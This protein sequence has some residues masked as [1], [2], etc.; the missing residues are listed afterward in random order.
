[1]TGYY[2][3][4]HE[5]SHN[6]GCNHNREVSS[7]T[8]PFSHAYLDPNGQFRTIMGYNCKNGCPRIQRF[9]N[10]EIDYSNKNIGS[11]VEDNSRQINNVAG[12]VADWYS[13][14]TETVV[15]VTESPTASPTN[16]PT[17]NLFVRNPNCMGVADEFGVKYLYASDDSQHGNNWFADF[18]TTGNYNVDDIDD[19]RLGFHT[20]GYMGLTGGE[21]LIRGSSI[22]TIS[23]DDSSEGFQNV[24]LTT[25]VK[26]ENFGRNGYESSIILTTHAEA[27][28]DD[29]VNGGCDGESYS[30][31]VNR[32]TGEVQFDKMYFKRGYREVRSAPISTKPESLAAG[33]PLQEYIGLKFVVY[34][35]GALDVKLELYIDQTGG[36][37]GGQWQLVHEFLDSQDAW[38]AERGWHYS[39]FARSQ[40]AMDD[41]EPFLG[42]R[43]YAKIILDGSHDT[44]I[45]LRK[46]SLRNIVL[47]ERIEGDA[48]MGCFGE[49]GTTN[50]GYIPPPTSSPVGSPTLNPTRPSFVPKIRENTESSG[51]KLNLQ[52]QSLNTLPT[53]NQEENSESKTQINLTFS[54]INDPGNNVDGNACDALGFKALYSSDTHLS[55]NDWAGDFEGSVVTMNKESPSHP[56]DERLFHGNDGNVIVGDNKA[57]FD[58]QAHLFIKA[59]E[60]FRSIEFTGYGMYEEDGMVYPESGLKMTAPLK[61]NSFDPCDGATYTVTITRATGEARF[62]KVYWAQR[63][64]VVKATPIVVQIEEFKGGLPLKEWVGMKFVVNVI[65]DNEV[66][67]ELYIDTTRG[68]DGGQWELV[69]ETTDRPGEWPADS[70]SR[71]YPY[72]NRATACSSTDGKPFTDSAPYCAL[73]AY[74][75]SST[76]VQWKDVTVRNISPARVSGDESCSNT[77]VE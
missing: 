42:H 16:A 55:N 44:E 18:P 8:F 73:A 74:G 53:S 19:Y 61:Y 17:A 50:L 3:F 9:S 20:L 46:I 59:E 47:T 27:Q 30:A 23:K 13:D 11:T 43:R 4:V 12:I 36:S 54:N 62:D 76:R 25:Y 67:L 10:P 37:N 77:W 64:R 45:R 75:N 24:E 57:I 1:M 28:F 32:L 29:T 69:L 14:E 51:P 7:R 66:K 70:S 65:N 52:F 34:N 31:S 33:I 72:F 40:C 35:Y 49:S 38:M 58:H 63:W 21:M 26:W 68:E 71:M 48:A 41:G 15:R 39:Y 6:M 5:I 22:M 2:S 60:S 56:D